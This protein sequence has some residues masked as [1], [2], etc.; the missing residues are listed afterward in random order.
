MPPYFPQK[1]IRECVP[2]VLLAPFFSLEGG[3]VPNDFHPL[4][5]LGGEHP[6]LELRSDLLMTWFVCLRISCEQAVQLHNLQEIQSDKG[7]EKKNRK[8]QQVPLDEGVLNLGMRGHFS[9]RSPPPIY[10]PRSPITARKPKPSNR[11]NTSSA[12]QPT[13]AEGVRRTSD[14]QL[15]GFKGLTT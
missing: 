9:R 8:F 2:S 4:G 3:G 14:R 13:V 1:I 10:P 11:P 6:S 5:R 15:L 7:T 12:H